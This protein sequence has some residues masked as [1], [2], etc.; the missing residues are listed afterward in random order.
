MRHAELQT[1]CTFCTR[2]KNGIFSYNDQ[3]GVQ[4]LTNVHLNRSRKKSRPASRLLCGSCGGVVCNPL[5]ALNRA[6]ASTTAY[7]LLQSCVESHLAPMHQS[8]VQAF[9][10]IKER[11]NQAGSRNPISEVYRPNMASYATF[12]RPHF[13]AGIGPHCSQ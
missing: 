1:P 8:H 11:N 3:K 10:F 7:S 2:M 13:N 4:T 12:Y 6:L 5:K 9:L